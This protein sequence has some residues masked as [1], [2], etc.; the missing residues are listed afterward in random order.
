MGK[1]KVES[2]DLFLGVQV[3]QKKGQCNEEKDGKERSKEG[4]EKG[5]VGSGGLGNVF[6]G[7]IF[8]TK[9]IFQG[10]VLTVV[11]HLKLAVV[12]SGIVFQLDAV[13]EVGKG[14]RAKVIANGRDESLKFGSSQVGVSKSLGPVPTIGKLV[15][16]H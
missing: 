3:H 13:N 16:S 2:I 14:D 4:I 15:G 12:L 6:T 7:L 9:K 11:D 8:Q 1:D 10:L 5:R